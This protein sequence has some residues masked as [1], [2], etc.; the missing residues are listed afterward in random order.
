MPRLTFWLSSLFVLLALPARGQVFTNRLDAIWPSAGRVGEQTE[1]A[2]AAGERLERVEKLVFSHEGIEAELQSADGQPQHG[3]FHVRVGPNVPPGDYEAWAVGRFGVSNP[4][5]FT[6]TQLPLRAVAAPSHD[7]SMPTPIALPMV[8]QARATGA[9]IDYYSFELTAPQSLVAVLRGQ[10]IDS[11]L[12]G[13]LQLLDEQSAV[14]AE[15]RG[16]DGYDCRLEIDA[17]QPGRYRL[18]V[19]D[20]LYR[21]GP[22]F[23]YQLWVGDAP[24]T[25]AAVPLHLAGPEAV[26]AEPH[27]DAFAAEAGV[28][29]SPQPIEVPHLAAWWFAE[30]QGEQQFEFTASQGD[31]LCIE[32][33]SQRLGQPT[34]ARLQLARVRQDEGGAERLEVLQT[35]EDSVVAG[36]G[37]LQP[38]SADPVTLFTAPEDGRYRIVLRDLDVGRSLSERQRY[39]LRVAP[40]TP[41]FS[42]VVY[43]PFPHRDLQQSRPHGGS[44]LPGGTDLL[45]VVAIREEGFAAPI[46]LEVAG[47]PEGVSARGGR[48]AP[49]QTVGHITLHAAEELPAGLHSFQVRG[50]AE[51]IA[52]PVE[53]RSVTIAQGRGNARELIQLR[54]SDA[55]R[56]HTSAQPLTPLSIEIGSDEPLRLTAGQSVALP[57]RLVRREG[58]S[59]P[60]V[61]RP[62][63]LPPGVSAGE[64]TIAGD[65]SEGVLELKAAAK[66]AAGEYSIWLQAESKVTFKPQPDAEPQSATLF[67]PSNVTPIHVVQP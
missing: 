6:V 13:G 66:A 7:A 60:V 41:H 46:Q 58:G 11:S 9:A 57:V 18:A 29:A 3:K 12:I 56:L 36:D 23:G 52:T 55:L 14:V 63:S 8:V 15:S 34:D 59:Q 48:I 4:R 31:R 37:V 47:L 43:R 24:L 22:I 40:N 67:L 16:G 30:D 20:F 38:R 2:V 45:R 33:I 27:R 26:S 10:T 35:V 65:K 62:Q 51:G 50:T 64:L 39:L 32:V 5:R 49:N 61:L 44:L 17:L 19:R 54:L 25:S 42:L 1:V 28:P 21:G 53:A